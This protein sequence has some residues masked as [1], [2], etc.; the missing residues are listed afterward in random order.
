MQASL[1]IVD[2][3]ATNRVALKVK[4]SSAWYE[5][6]TASTGA[7]ALAAIAD[8]LPNLV[9][10]NSTL[11]DMT[12]ADFSAKVK[13]RMGQAAPPILALTEEQEA[14]EE[15]LRAGAEDA[16]P[17]PVDDRLL[18]ARIRSVLRNSASESEWRL[19]DGTTRALGF[20]EP[21]QGFERAI[22]VIHLRDPQ[23]RDGNSLFGL[24]QEPGLKVVTMSIDLALK[25]LD[26]TAQSSVLVLDLPDTNP[27]RWLS[28]LSDLRANM[29]TRH[30]AILVIAP[31]DRPDL[32]AQALA[33][34]RSAMCPCRR[35]RFGHGACTS[36]AR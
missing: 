18:F 7:D 5:V 24:I 33:K 23:D 4:L 2:S 1:L 32:A 6:S 26:E 17:F 29:R 19:R 8:T 3:I 36:G 28:L 14:R 31:A 11:P 15:L 34:P 9:I 30:K 13:T 35:W 27:E 22:P 25:N 12:A 10:V 21:V 20:A 16:L